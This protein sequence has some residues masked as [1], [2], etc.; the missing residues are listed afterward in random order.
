[1][2]GAVLFAFP[3]V[4]VA[5]NA[6]GGTAWL[7]APESIAGICIV[8]GLIGMLITAALFGDA[9][10]RDVQTRM[11]PLF[12][13]LPI[14][15]A[16]YLGGRFLGALAVNAVLLLALPLGTL[17]AT[18]TLPLDAAT[19]GPTQPLAY[20]QAY[21]LFLLP[22]LLLTAAILFAIAALGRQMLPAYLGGIGLFVVYGLATRLQSFTGSRTLAAL[23]DPFGAQAVQGLTRYWT[24]L[25]RNTRLIG[26]PETLLWNRLLWT[27]VAMGVLALLHARFRAGAAVSASA[28]SSRRRDATDKHTESADLPAM[29]V[30]PAFGPATD[31]RQALA[32][33]WFSLRELIF[34][35]TFL[36]VVAGA[37]FI[38]FWF[39][40]QAGAVVFETAS[41]PVTQLIAGTVLT[42]P[43]AVLMPLVITLF[44]GELV[45]SERDVRLSAITDATPVPDWVP[46]A[47]RFAAL[48]CMLVILQTVLLAAG[49]LLQALHGYY[50]FELGL[51]V[52]IL[53]GLTLPGYLLFAALAMTVHVVLEQKYA[54]HLAI[55]LAYLF[56]VFAR[57][58]GVHHRLLVYGSDPGWIYSD[59]SGFGPFVAPFVWFKLYWGAWALLLA[60][61]ASLLRARGTERGLR[62]RFALARTRFTGRTAGAAIAAVALIATLGGFIFYNTNILNEYRTPFEADALRAE[63]ERRYKRYANMPQP[64]IARAEL[65]IELEPDA[66]A[67]DLRGTYR[68]VNRSSVPIAAIHVSTAR[69]LTVRSLAVDGAARASDDAK[70]HYRIFTLARPLQPGQAVRMHF[71]LEFRPRGFR[72]DRMPAEVVRNGTYFGRRWLPIVGYQPALE[73][74]TAES[75]REHGLAPRARLA[76]DDAQGRRYASILRDADLVELDTIIGTKAGETAVTLGALQKTW[77]RNGRRYFHYRTDGAVTFEDLPFLSAGYAVRNDRWNGIALQIFHHPRHTFNLARMMG[78]MKGALDYSSRAFGPY[79]F[80]E[81]RI[82]EFPRY[83]SFARAHPHTITFSEGSAFLTEVKQGDLD[84]PFFVTAHETAHQWWGEQLRAAHVRGMAFVIESLAQYTALLAMEKTLGPAQARRFYDF[85]MDDYLRG[86]SNVASREVPLLDVEDQPY[87]FYQKGAVAMYM[88]REQLGEERVNSAL[89]TFLAKYR[90]GT[91]PYPTARDLYAELQAVTPVEQREL[92]RDLFETIT[93]WDVRALAADVTRLPDGTYRVALEVAASK[94]R[95]DGAGNPKAV[96]MNDLVEIGVFAADGEPLYLAKHRV[97]SGRQTIIVTVTRPP[98]RAAVDPLHKLI[99]VETADNGVAAGVRR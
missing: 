60:I 97:R 33:A 9:A 40:Q 58:L 12:H 38:V 24:T 3:F 6:D 85:A 1:L 27:T 43:F 37:L 68:L 13:T 30:D 57:P 62:R 34:S 96:P 70:L 45:W 49:V 32:I 63:Y 99:Q 78:G 19:L 2:Y 76:D 72:N 86:R 91:P 89:R 61:A 14:G 80:R 65:Q 51:Y 77:T 39:G 41:W 83:A 67:A 73:L 20:V 75:R 92:L 15:R 98:A 95:S 56:T 26:L 71:A 25:E 16:A 23:L 21:I 79:Q 90:A 46:L 31:V 66:H 54:A 48:S 11:A 47:G 18:L 88:L 93:L 10:T 69:E 74:Q 59:M 17:A 44:A 28:S 29:T 94:S 36:F 64:H 81:L 7:N 22:N 35:R 4:A 82:V 5:A 53:F 8:G 52:R 50:D 87:L 42:M 84:R 55:V